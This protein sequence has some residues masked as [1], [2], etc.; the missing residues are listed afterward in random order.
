MKGI[1]R[2]LTENQAATDP[3]A[4]DPRLRGR[5]YA[6]PFQDVWQAAITLCGGGLRGWSIGG[7]DDRSGVIDVV[8]R[9]GIFGHEGDVRVEIGLDENAQTRVDV[10]AVSRAERGDLGRTRRAIDRFLR[11][12]DRRLDARP[13][14]ILDPTRPPA[15]HKGS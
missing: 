5:T 1:L 11:N 14:Q 15:W 3:N 2:G 6:I 13:D 4:V 12:L 7:A 8:T 10:R 9:T